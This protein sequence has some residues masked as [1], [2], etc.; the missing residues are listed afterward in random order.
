MNRSSE[1]N[2]LQFDRET[3][4]IWNGDDENEWMNPTKTPGLSSLQSLVE[5][6][7]AHAFARNCDS[8]IIIIIITLPVL[9][10]AAYIAAAAAD[11]LLDWM[12]V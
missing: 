10:Q 3:I 2:S 5:I 12:M 8:D 9:L 1:I 7:S 6:C 4:H 11:M